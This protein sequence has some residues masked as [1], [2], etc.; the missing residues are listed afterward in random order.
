MLLPARQLRHRN[1]EAESEETAAPSTETEIERPGLL[2]RITQAIYV[3]QMRRAQ[4][5]IDCRR[6]LIATLKRRLIERRIA[7]PPRLIWQDDR[8]PG[9]RETARSEPAAEIARRG[10]RSASA[11]VRAILSEWRRRVRSRRELRKLNDRDLKDFQWTR[12]DAVA[13]S[14]KPFWRR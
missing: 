11:A 2:D 10:V 5:E 1:H 7:Y 6:D 4:R 8:P 3:T 14:R 12:A 9:D 13:E